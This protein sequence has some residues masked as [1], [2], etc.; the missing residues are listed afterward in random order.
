MSDTPADA[1]APVTEAATSADTGLTVSN[2]LGEAAAEPTTENVEPAK[3]EEAVEDKPEDKA[4]DKADGAPEAYEDFALPEGVELNDETLTDY[5]AMAKELNLSQDAAQ[6]LVEF[7]TTRLK[8]AAEAPYKLWADTQRQWQADIKSDPDIGGTKLESSL[9]LAARAIDASEGNAL[10][11][12]LSF[13]GFGN[14]PA[15]VRHFVEVG[16]VVEA[17]QSANLISKGQ[18]L[19]DLVK[20][21]SAPE[22]TTG[23][24]VTGASKD[25]AH[26]LYPDHS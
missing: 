3:S 2:M 9:S 21:L 23:R 13:T 5:K 20:V 18:G 7:G 25:T 16:R 11:E 19:K 12:G 14:N 6:K 22:F 10:R 8:E 4:E 26:V 1:A 17:A 24:P 15:A